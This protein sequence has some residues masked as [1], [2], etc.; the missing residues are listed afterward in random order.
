MVQ[1]RD[2]E[3]LRAE[4]AAL[5]SENAALRRRVAGAKLAGDG[6]DLVANERPTSPMSRVAIL[7][8]EQKVLLA[9]LRLGEELV[10]LQK[11]NEVLFRRGQQLQDENRA[12]KEDRGSLLNQIQNPAITNSAETKHMVAHYPDTYSHAAPIQPKSPTVMMSGSSEVANVV[13]PVPKAKCSPE[14]KAERRE[15]VASLLKAGLNQDSHLVSDLRPCAI[16]LSSMPRLDLGSPSNG[17]SPSRGRE[18]SP[19]RGTGAWARESSHSA[20]VEESKYMREVAIK[21]MLRGISQ[22][23]PRR[24]PRS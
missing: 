18:I 6:T 14:E 19:A 1:Q 17:Q 21:D 22:N 24:T 4:H 15:L 7:S 10:A 8:R 3:A 2:L 12:L 5:E 23:T 9:S 16:Q 13:S 20:A 11:S